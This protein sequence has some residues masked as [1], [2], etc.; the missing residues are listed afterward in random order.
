MCGSL[1][2]NRLTRGLAGSKRLSEESIKGDVSLK[3]SYWLFALI[4]LV[5]S[6]LYSCGDDGTPT[7]PPVKY[8]W[9]TM[10]SGTGLNIYGLWGT[11][12]SNVYAVGSEGAI[13]HYDGSSWTEVAYAGKPSVAL[14]RIWGVANDTIFVVGDYRHIIRYNGT[15]WTVSQYPATDEV[16][17]D[18]HFRDVWGTSG[19]NVY[20]VGS[21]G[22]TLHY[23][24]SDWDEMPNPVGT[25]LLT[26]VWGSSPDV[27]L[28][29]GANGTFLLKT[30]GED[31][32]IIVDT[33]TDNLVLAAS[34]TSQADVFFVGEYNASATQFG[35]HTAIHLKVI[36]N[37][38]IGTS[39][40]NLGAIWAT[41]VNAL[42]DQDLN[43]VWAY[44][45]GK[46]FVVGNNGTI[47]RLTY[48]TLSWSTMVSPTSSHLRCVWG[49]SGTDVFAAGD[50]GVIVHYG[51]Q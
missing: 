8:G 20:I 3:R 33:M 30:P 38:T 22:V 1:I 43:D 49:S 40:D 10:S 37:G 15:T 35:R 27:V 9:S 31:W 51:P 25:T 19:S 2:L 16:P 18:A 48:S 6:L 42:P 34:G 12:D 24:G 45:P 44:T 50:A 39:A 29:C 47:I 17:A 13:L 28:A 23:D 4:L 7:E 36:T 5:I 46:A 21:Q 14:R 11:S 26:G 41:L 32:D